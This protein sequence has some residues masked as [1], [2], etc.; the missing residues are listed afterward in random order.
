MANEQVLTKV[1]I[2]ANVLTADKIAASATSKTL[3]HRWTSFVKTFWSYTEKSSQD[4][5][6]R[7][8]GLL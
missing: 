8:E 6:K 1:N 4:D 7:Y 2:N 3:K 5:V